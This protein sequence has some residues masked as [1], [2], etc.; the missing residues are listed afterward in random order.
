MCRMSFKVSTVGSASDC[1][2]PGRRGQPGM[3]RWDAGLQPRLRTGQT[4]KRQEAEAV[5]WGCGL[6]ASALLG[7]L[8]CGH[9]GLRFPGEGAAAAVAAVTR[10]TG[11]GRGG[12]K[13]EVNALLQPQDSAPLA[14]LG[15]PGPQG[16]I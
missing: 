8:E 4:R 1:P 14:L 16:G 12:R 10:V 13:P 5:R 6:P 11:P 7:S 2:G 15:V 9:L 3:E